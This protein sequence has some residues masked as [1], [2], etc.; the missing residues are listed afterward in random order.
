MIYFYAYF[1]LFGATL[2]MTSQ[3][4]RQKL[5]RPKLVFDA[6]PQFSLNDISLHNT[7]MLLFIAPVLFVT[8]RS[9]AIDD[10]GLSPTLIDT[11]GFGV[12]LLVVASVMMLCLGALE[13]YR[14]RTS[15]LPHPGRCALTGL[16]TGIGILGLVMG[17]QHFA[18]TD[19]QTRLVNLDLI[20]S[21]VTDIDCD[22]P[23][24]AVNWSPGLDAG[25]EY[26]CPTQGVLYSSG[27]QPFI[28]WPNY[29]DGT[30]RQ[31]ASLIGRQSERNDLDKH[32]D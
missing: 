31:L 16:V 30:S 8:T 4:F 15:L 10:L 12:S 28:P 9:V 7:V 17:T 26:R 13:L 6:E 22:S 23:V 14:L 1:L 24:I 2:F 20:R 21:A 25:A 18:F 11:S 3:G 32:N 5:A 19:S 27:D 29:H